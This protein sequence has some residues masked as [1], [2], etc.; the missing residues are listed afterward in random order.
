M[1]VAS[2]LRLASQMKESKNFLEIWE[3]DVV[4]LTLTT[5]AE[6]YKTIRF[7]YRSYL[8]DTIPAINT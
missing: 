5:F 3:H 4:I 1:F 6:L 8:L 7:R 2:L